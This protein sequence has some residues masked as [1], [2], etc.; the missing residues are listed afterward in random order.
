MKNLIVT[1]LVASALGLG[2]CASTPLPGM[3]AEIQ[4]SANA[5]GDYS[6]DWNKAAKAEQQAIDLIESGEK[7][8]ARNEKKIRD[9]NKDIREAEKAIVRG[10]GEIRQGTRDAEVAKARRI[11]IENDFKNAVRVDEQQQATGSA[12]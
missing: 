3:G 8:I 6:K 7:R 1:A 2:A 9:A 10:E 5:Y 11:A 4:A 12:S